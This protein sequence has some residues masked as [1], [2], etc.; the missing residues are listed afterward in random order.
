[1]KRGG[2]KSALPQSA[3]L[4][5]NEDPVENP[6][7]KKSNNPIG[8]PKGEKKLDPRFK[9]KADE[10]K[11]TIV[12]VKKFVAKGTIHS[13]D[14]EN[15]IKDAVKGLFLEDFDDQGEGI[16]EFL[17]EK[18]GR[19]DAN[20]SEKKDNFTDALDA[21]KAVS[22]L[23]KEQD[24][25]L[26]SLRKA[27]LGMLEQHGRF[28]EVGQLALKYYNEVFYTEKTAEAKDEALVLSAL[29]EIKKSKR[30]AALDTDRFASE[31][32]QSMDA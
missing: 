29:Q 27:D 14:E 13:D 4:P 15:E 2:F 11:T 18:S 20:V 16:L 31:A 10:I 19:Q 7:Q 6:P 9:P 26:A 1:M 5:V 17:A 22:G 30:D 23:T 28:L 25:F 3:P 21:I 8:R 12:T 24:N 32:S